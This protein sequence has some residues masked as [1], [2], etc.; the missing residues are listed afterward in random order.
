MT[1]ESFFGTS[2]LLSV[3]NFKVIDQLSS[4]VKL[5]HVIKTQDETIQQRSVADQVRRVSN[6]RQR[7]ESEVLSDI[8][9]IEEEEYPNLNNGMACMTDFN[10][11]NQRFD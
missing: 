6:R 1:K 11:L 3:D 5:K 8:S 9:E 2:Y 4:L 7:L 10:E